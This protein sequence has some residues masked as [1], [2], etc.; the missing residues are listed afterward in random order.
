MDQSQWRKPNRSDG[1]NNCVELHP[2]GWLRDSKHPA[3]PMLRVDLRQLV[4]A[5]RTCST[6][7][8]C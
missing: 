8:A 4:L 1:A 7:R 5:A 2:D 3:G 6:M